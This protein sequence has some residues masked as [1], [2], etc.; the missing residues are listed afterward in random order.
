MFFLM[1]I[2]YVTETHEDHHETLR[3]F[4]R[5]QKYVA[6]GTIK[7]IDLGVGLKF[8]SNTPLEKQIDQHEVYFLK[9]DLSLSETQQTDLCRQNPIPI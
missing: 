4:K 5:W 1:L 6:T 8:L 3:M 2:G 9:G 7:G